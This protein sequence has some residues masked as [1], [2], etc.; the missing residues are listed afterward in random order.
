MPKKSFLTEVR[1]VLQNRAR[2]TMFSRQKI[3]VI[4]QTALKNLLLLTLL[5]AN[6]FWPFCW[7]RLQYIDDM[8][9]GTVGKLL[10]LTQQKQHQQR[11]SGSFE[12]YIVT[13]TGT[14]CRRW[15]ETRHQSK[16]FLHV[17][18]QHT[19]IALLLLM[20]RPATQSGWRSAAGGRQVRS[21]RRWARG[22]QRRHQPPDAAR[23]RVLGHVGRR[24]R[25]SAGRTESVDKTTNH[26]A[27]V[28]LQ[29]H[30]PSSPT[31]TIVVVVVV[32]SHRPETGTRKTFTGNQVSISF[33][34]Q[35]FPCLAA[36]VAWWCLWR[37]A[38]TRRIQDSLSSGDFANGIQ[39][40]VFLSLKKVPSL[41]TWRPNLSTWNWT[42]CKQCEV[43]SVCHTW[44]G[45]SDAGF[46][47][48]Q[49]KLT[50]FQ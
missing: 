33:W 25:R 12:K 20:V 4:M 6:N 44:Q 8:H 24:R 43:T 50:W 34:R 26:A 27:S 36:A 40:K 42:T 37:R 46:K 1:N 7:N 31:I 14:G 10:Q 23:Q 48:S 16:V 28:H 32:M 45:A 35:S 11:W 15:Y 47:A 38:L 22:G 21:E 18:V 2:S 3:S 39:P 30:P 29:H 5:R 19:A 13:V 41:Y 17:V 49:V 9:S